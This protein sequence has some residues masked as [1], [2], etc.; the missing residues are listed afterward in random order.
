MNHSA[1][2]ETSEAQSGAEKELEA[3]DSKCMTPGAKC[4]KHYH[5]KHGVDFHVNGQKRHICT[6][7]HLADQPTDVQQKL[8]PVLQALL[9]LPDNSAPKNQKCQGLENSRICGEKCSSNIY[10]TGSC[11]LVE[12]PDLWYFC[13]LECA[14]QRLRFTT[15]GNWR[16]T[17]NKMDAD[18]QKKQSKK[19]SMS[20]STLAAKNMEVVD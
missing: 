2:T 16:S 20:K 6:I 8:V 3:V 1:H 17:V 18:Y 12:K 13:S 15:A 5:S 11:R 4:F 9:Q 10:V 19:N 14:I 7:A